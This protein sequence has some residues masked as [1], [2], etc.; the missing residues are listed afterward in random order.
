MDKVQER[1]GS[2]CYIPS[3]EPFTIH[4]N[5]RYG[6][7]IYSSFRKLERLKVQLAK[8]LNHTTFFTRWKSQGIIPTGFYVKTPINSRR[9]S[10]IAQR[11]S[12]ALRD[13]L[14][15]Q[16]CNKVLLHQ[17]IHKLEN[18]LKS[19]ISETNGRWKKSHLPKRSGF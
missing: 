17:K 6:P 16:W 3:S 5:N 10:K 7:S 1:N 11:A 9:S 8:T 15:F 12:N 14:R 2:Q 4:L 19:S 13:R 18:F